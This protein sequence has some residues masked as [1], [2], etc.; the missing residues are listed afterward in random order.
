MFT[1]QEHQD[2]QMLLVKTRLSNE[3]RKQ[4]FCP[5]S[6]A[7]KLTKKK[8]NISMKNF[9]QKSGMEKVNC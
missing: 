7:K 9:H 5:K 3:K 2:E 6:G 8:E 1:F 4:I